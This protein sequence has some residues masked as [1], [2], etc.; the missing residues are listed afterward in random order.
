MAFTTQAEADSV[1]TKTI[2]MALEQFS[3]IEFA[4]FSLAMQT[5]GELPQRSPAY[6]IARDL[7]LIDEDGKTGFALDVVQYACSIELER[8]TNKG[9]M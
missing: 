3:K 5:S 9:E 4:V 8:R 1:A 7:S 2:V 6:G